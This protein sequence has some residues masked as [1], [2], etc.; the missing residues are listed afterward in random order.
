MNLA[1]FDLDRT[2]LT[3][4]S[5]FRYYLH[6]FR[7]GIFSPLSLGFVFFWGLLFR[8]FHLPPQKLHHAIFQKLL[9]NLP[10][11]S[12]SDPA[13]F[14][15]LQLESFLYE[16]LV[17]LFRQAKEKR[18]YTLLLSSSPTFLLEPLAKRFGFDEWKGSEY[19]LDKEG[20]LEH[21]SFLMSGDEKR[22]LALQLSKR[23]CI[24]K[25]KIIVYTDSCWDLPLL[26]MAGVPVAV[27]PDRRLKAICK[28]RGWKVFS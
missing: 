17:H 5:S 12:L 14:F 16:P 1:I 21:I 22:D 18:V 3:V 6:L 13:S 8:F 2:L 27:R 15:S 10:F 7:M 9:K 11:S 25:G 19:G 4:N 24:E 20:R 28:K 23:L 26:E